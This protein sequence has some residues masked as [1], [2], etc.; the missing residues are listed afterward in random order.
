MNTDKLNIQIISTT[1]SHLHAEIFFAQESGLFEGHFPELPLLPGVVQSHLAIRL[2]EKHVGKAISFGGFKNMKFFSPIFP[3]TKVTLQ[4]DL[5]S[6][7]RQFTFRYFHG[8]V[9]YSKGVVVI[10][11]V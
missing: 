10:T 4:C 3:N 8:E 9:N 6:A 5:E 11:D 7:K 1:D 2:F